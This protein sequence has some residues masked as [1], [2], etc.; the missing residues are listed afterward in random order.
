MHKPADNVYYDLYGRRVS[1]PGKGIYI[2]NGRKV[3]L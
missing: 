1:H 2:Q 3:K